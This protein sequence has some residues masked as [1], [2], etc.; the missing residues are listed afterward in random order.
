MKN[1]NIL[2]MQAAAAALLAGLSVGGQP[3]F[4]Q[5]GRH[6]HISKPKR[7]RSTNSRYQP[8]SGEQE[9]YRRRIGGFYMERK[10]AAFP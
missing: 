9:C 7:S 10:R 1:M 8:G 2:R 4:M 5:R 6:L 3:I